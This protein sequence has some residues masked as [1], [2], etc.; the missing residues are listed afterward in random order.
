MQAP[1]IHGQ[2]ALQRNFELKTSE[3]CSTKGPDGHW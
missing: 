1:G 2:L 3:V